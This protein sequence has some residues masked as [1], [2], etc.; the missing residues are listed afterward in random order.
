VK[1][2]LLLA[3]ACFCVAPASA[4]VILDSIWSEEGGTPQSP[5]LGFGAHVA[6]ANEP[7]FSAAIAFTSDGD[8][9]QDCSGTWI[10]N[11][12][13]AG[14]VLTAA[15]CIEDRPAT[16]F[17]YR[18]VG[19]TMLGGVEVNVH[20]DWNGDAS[21][22][23]GFDIAIIKLDQRVTGAGPQPL[24]YDGEAENGRVLTF[25]GFGQRGRG[26]IGPGYSY[27][28]PA[29]ERE[30]KAAAQGRVDDVV[31]FETL[32]AEDSGNYLTILLMKEDGSLPNPYGGAVRPSSRL[33]GLL[34]PGDAGC[35]AWFKLKDGRW[36]I[37]GVASDGSEPAVY[38]EKSWFVRVSHHADWIRSIYPGARFAHD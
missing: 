10:G 36:V 29:N 34:A 33:A 38:G 21:Q 4:V 2:W 32:E 8:T 35:A 13:S 20:P 30:Q 26:S 27:Y 28:A 16:T 19:G 17:G 18:S 23:T 7:Q 31:A 1:F 24:L 9:W 25:A 15:H 3:A 5:A 22:R 14:Y 6:L 12:A 11:D 37:A